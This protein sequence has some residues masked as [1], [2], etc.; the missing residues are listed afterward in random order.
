[1]KIVRPT[2]AMPALAY[3]KIVNR[4]QAAQAEFTKLAAWEIANG[5]PRTPLAN[6]CR[7]AVV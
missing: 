1:M 2:L 3:M 5:F 4:Y 7:T 6:E